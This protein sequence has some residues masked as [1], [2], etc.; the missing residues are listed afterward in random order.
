MRE[1]PISDPEKCKNILEQMLTS[2]FKRG[3]GKTAQYWDIDTFQYLSNHPYLPYWNDAEDEHS[4]RN[5]TC[6]GRTMQVTRSLHDALIQLRKIQLMRHVMD[7]DTFNALPA[8][9]KGGSM[10]VKISL[11][12]ALIA[13]PWFLLPQDPV[14][15][16]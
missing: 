4:Y 3:D 11:I 6:N 10:S 9:M 12:F 7:V 1:D 2:S 13:A 8:P 14:Q 15:M 5:I 16:G